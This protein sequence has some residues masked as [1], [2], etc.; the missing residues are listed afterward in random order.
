[1]R[2]Q[3]WPRARRDGYRR[4]RALGQWFVLFLLV[5][6]IVGIVAGARVLGAF[7]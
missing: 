4:A 7:S 3:D 5:L 2:R 1:M 6:G